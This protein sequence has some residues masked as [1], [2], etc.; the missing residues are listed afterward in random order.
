MVTLNVK[1]ALICLVL[2]AL[3]ILIFYLITLVRKLLIT[4]SSTNK[5]LDDAKVVS[6][7]ASEKA[8]EVDGIMGDISGAVSNITSEVKQRQ[9]F[10]KT[11]TNVGKTAAQAVSYIKH[12]KEEGVYKKRRH[13]N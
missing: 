6:A 1:E 3:L 2:I 4:V 13:R 11:V 7:I 5:V 9:G 10:I 8:T 12:N